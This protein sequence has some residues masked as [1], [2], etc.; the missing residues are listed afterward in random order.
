MRQ[1]GRALV[2]IVCLATA[3]FPFFTW[4]DRHHLGD[5][6]WPQHAR[7]HLIWL[8]TLTIGGASLS[9]AA[10]VRWWERSPDARLAATLFPCFVWSACLIEGLVLSPLLGVAMPYTQARW[11]VIGQLEANVLGIAAPLV[12][13]V[14]GY[15]MDK[16]ARRA[17]APAAASH[18]A[19]A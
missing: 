10:V 6:E 17:T 9:L 13:A 16:R 5:P 3:V 2:G 15:W 11:K 4:F 14:I 8:M 1:P 12:I 19:S 7:A 18:Q